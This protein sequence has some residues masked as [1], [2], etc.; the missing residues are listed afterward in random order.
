MEEQAVASTVTK[1]FWL[2]NISVKWLVPVVRLIS[3]FPLL[4][5]DFWWSGQWARHSRLSQRTNEKE[6]LQSKME[7]MIWWY[8]LENEE[9]IVAVNAIY[10]IA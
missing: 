2:E 6:F 10:V 9:M 3:V 5:Q 7:G 8:S 4:F 1:C